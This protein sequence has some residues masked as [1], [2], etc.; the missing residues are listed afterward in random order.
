MC[1]HCKASRY[2]HRQSWVE[3]ERRADALTAD[4]GSTHPYYPRSLGLDG[5]AVLLF[6]R[7]DKADRLRPNRSEES[8]VRR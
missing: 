4:C 8:H 3:P 2:M 1:I 5:T 6:P 7:L